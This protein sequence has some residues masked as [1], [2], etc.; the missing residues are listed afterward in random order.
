MQNT[1]DYTGLEERL[2]A[3][4]SVLA[5][6]QREIVDHFD[7]NPKCSLD[8]TGGTGKTLMT[9]YATFKSRPKTVLIL[10]SKN[11]FYTWQ[12]EVKKWFPE[13]SGEEFFSVIE[14]QTPAKRAKCWQK[15][16]L[17]YICSYGTFRSDKAKALALRADVILSDEYHKG[18]LKNRKSATT[19]AIKELEPFAKRIHPASGSAIRKG[20]QDLWSLLNILARRAFTSY[21]AFVYKYCVVIDGMF[22][23]EID[24]PKNEEEMLRLI[25]PY[26]VRVPRSISDAQKPKLLRQII[27]LKK[28]PL[29]AKHYKELAEELVTIYETSAGDFDIIASPTIVGVYIK[30]R[31]LLICP[32]MIGIQDMGAGLDMVLDICSDR[33]DYHTVI[34]TPFT[35]GIP[36]FKEA[37]EKALPDYRIF[38]LQGG[39]TW[40]KIK[41]VTDDFRA[42]RKTICI[43]SVMYS[44]SFELESAEHCH[45]LGYDWDQNSNEQCE[46]RLQ[47]MTADIT[48]PITAYYY[49]YKESVD[50]DIMETLNTNTMNVKKTFRSVDELKTHLGG[51]IV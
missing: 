16:A 29:Q 31:K 32:Q 38:T 14:G 7:L 19:L 40:E 9:L 33:D 3:V 21:W 49:Q 4:Y 17:F 50:E 25:K 1:P 39:D 22:G 15:D 45:F 13:W 26:Y 24:G 48:R 42:D 20:P 35:D 5:P 12:K 10:C 6:F 51:T 36:I 37:L 46:W 34:F 30:L 18:G 44:Q 43:C 2:Q 47:R 28:T 8:A 23:K 11:A 27:P 41:Q